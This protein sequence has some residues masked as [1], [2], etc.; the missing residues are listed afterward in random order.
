MSQDGTAQ[1]PRY[2]TGC[3]QRKQHSSL[4]LG[5][6]CVR[7]RVRSIPRRWSFQLRARLFQFI[8]RRL[9]PHFVTFGRWLRDDLAHRI[10]DFGDWLQ[11]AARERSI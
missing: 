8:R 6:Y 4:W 2:C 9:A 7:C 10:H 11:R 5:T 1:L 3:C